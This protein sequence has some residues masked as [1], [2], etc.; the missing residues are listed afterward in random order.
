MFRIGAPDPVSEPKAFQFGTGPERG[1]AV[2]LANELRSLFTL[3]RQMY[4]SAALIAVAISLLPAH[5]AIIRFEGNDGVNDGQYSVGPYRLVIDGKAY[6]GMCYDF[7]HSVSLNQSWEADLLTY[8]DLSKAYFA[9][10]PDARDR[11]EEGAWL[12]T[13]LLASSA[14]T[15]RIGIQ[16]AA[17][18]LFSNSAP[19][20]GASIWTNGAHQAREQGL[21]G[22]DLGTIRIINTPQGSA[23]VQGFLVAG[24]EAAP[25]PEPG[26]IG[27]IGCGLA[28]LGLLR[29]SLRRE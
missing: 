22:I 28:G 17:W 4:R 5:A 9:S 7:N 23:P 8:D 21:P 29:R 18:S 3:M 24:F 11:Y 13:T 15:D 1:G 20:Q 25:A 14:A 12:L 2:R 6:L 19:K 10:Q 16:H 26:T 27:L